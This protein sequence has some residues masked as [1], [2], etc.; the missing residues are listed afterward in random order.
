MSKL[1]KYTLER[2]ERKEKW[3]LTNDKT[4][5]TIKSFSTKEEALKR[6]V[7][8]NALGDKGGSVKIQKLDGKFQE[9]RT[10]PGTKDPKTSRG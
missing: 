6:G 9:E 3:T 7:L 5:K 2:S 8:E 10:F 1:Q 4:N